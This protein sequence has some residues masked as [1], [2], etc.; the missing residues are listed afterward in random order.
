MST[1]LQTAKLA[2]PSR[3]T[4]LKGS[5]A[6]STGL[7][8]GFYVPLLTQEA[9]AQGAATVAPEVNAWVAIQPDDKVVVRI[10]RSA[11]VDL[12]RAWAAPAGPTEWM[13]VRAQSGDIEEAH[14]GDAP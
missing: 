6:A 9:R 2:Q 10:A 11:R 8:I 3:R 13:T 5:A 12:P 1:S 14:Q 4:F 7:V